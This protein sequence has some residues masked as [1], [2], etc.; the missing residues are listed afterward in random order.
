[1]TPIPEVQ[2][3]PQ[4]HRKFIFITSL[5]VFVIAVPTF[6]F[7]AVGYRFDFSGEARSIKSVGGMY[8]SAVADGAEIFVDDQ[9]VEDMRIFQR[10]AYI[11]NLTEGVHQVHVQG[12]GLQTWVK[13]LPVFPHFVTEVLSFNMPTVPQVRM[14]AQ[15][16]TAAQEQVLFG[17]A[18]TTPLM[19]A[20]ST[21]NFFIATSTATSSYVLN[22]EYAYVETLFAS[23]TEE[24]E[25]IRTQREI[26]AQTFQFSDEVATT[27]AVTATTTK[28]YRDTKLFEKDGEVYIAWEGSDNDVPFYYCVRYAEA[29]STAS[30]YGVHVQDDIAAQLVA[31]D[32]VIQNVDRV[33]EGRHCRSAIMIDRMEQKVIWFDYFPNSRD[34][35]LMQVSDGLYVVEADDRAWQN[36]QLLY[37]GEGIQVVKDGERI[38]VRDGVHYIEV[39]TELQK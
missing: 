4:G 11:Q 2:P 21:Q 18:S 5:V 9:P 1:M 34:F 25:R 20:S 38:F 31:A 17:A 26:L 28:I 29:T 36:T 12:E 24:T 32:G 22:P 10:A 14:V 33:L 39:Y 23:S 19:F 7:Y 13:K 37:P 35:V 15:Y 8:V 30:L 3:L 16:N 6:V 27:T